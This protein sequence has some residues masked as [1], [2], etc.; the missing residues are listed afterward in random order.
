[1]DRIFLN[2][3]RVQAVI[4]I[5]EWEQRIR[6]SVT[7]DLE[8]ATDARRGAQADSIDDALNYKNVAKRLIAH[9][10]ASKF[11][12]VETLAESIARIVVEEFA[13]PWVKVRIGKPG[14][15]EGSKEVG[16]VIER[17]AQDYD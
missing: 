16:I 8:M 2:G 15:V 12:L 13:V 14:A 9:V 5:W 4:G 11:R 17:T 7:L 10:E 6:Q 3:L 1:M